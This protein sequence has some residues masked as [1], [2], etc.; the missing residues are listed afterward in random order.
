MAVDNIENM[1]GASEVEGVPILVEGLGKTTVGVTTESNTF[2]A[3]KIPI[4]LIIS[5]VYGVY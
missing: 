5:I 4:E 2:Q 1:T 3:E